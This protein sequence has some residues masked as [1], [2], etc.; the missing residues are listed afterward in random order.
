[1]YCPACGADAGDAKFCPECGTD[2]KKLVGPP[3][4]SACGSEVP[5]GAKFCPECGEPARGAA[6]GRARDA[7]PDEGVELDEGVEAAGTASGGGGRRTGTRGKS[8]GGG[9][10]RRQQPR[11][12]QAAKGKGG[13][14]APPRPV[15]RVSP[16]VAWGAIIAVVAVAVVVL[17]FYATGRGDSGTAAG[18]AATTSQPVAADTS[19]SYGELVQRANALYDQGSAQLQTKQYGQASEYFLA[20][21]KVYGAAWKQQATDPAVGTDYATSLFYSGKIAAAV[22][23]VDKVLAESPEFQTAWFNK[24]NYLAQKARDAETAGS[25]KVAKAA[26]AGARAAYQKA[27][28]LD[29]KSSSGQQAQQQLSALPA[30]SP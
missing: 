10:Q 27:I 2:L 6:A 20:A 7:A 19:G 21:S 14:A 4:C 30:P 1:M 28:D 9:Q 16:L 26:Y 18:P 12:E 8:A 5:E 24:G 22:E 11:T 3:V 13:R 23:Q 29:P 25:G 15:G 17:V